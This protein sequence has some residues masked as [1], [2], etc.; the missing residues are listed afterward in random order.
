M[1]T[2]NMA[3]DLD[4]L[5][6]QYRPLRLS[7]ITQFAPDCVDSAT[8]E[9]LPS[10]IDEQFI[11]LT[12]EYDVSSPVDYPGYIKILLT[13]RTKYSFIDI[14]NKKA[15]AEIL[16]DIT[17]PMTS[18]IANKVY[19]DG[20]QEESLAELLEDI[21]SRVHLPDLETLILGRLIRGHRLFDIRRYLKENHTK[22]STK[23][24]TSAINN[25]KEICLLVQSTPL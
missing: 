18:N 17:D 23:E 6:E 3:R 24:V 12:L 8:K 2:V 5:Y 19:T 13:L 14:R 25:I 11:R 16:E 7:L 1:A 21:Y 4:R 9:E 15:N 10:Y 22:Y 20:E